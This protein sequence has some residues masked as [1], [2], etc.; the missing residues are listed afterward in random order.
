[1]S[2]LRIS[3]ILSFFLVLGSFA[4]PLSCSQQ[5]SDV[6]RLLQQLESDETTD[7]AAEQLLKLGRSDPKARQDLVRHLP[8]MIQKGP[9]ESRP[10]SNAVQ[11]AG[12]LK[13]A[14]AAP[15]LAKW[16]YE[17]A[18]GTL[19]LATTT[20]LEDDPAAKALAQIGDPSLPAVSPLLKSSNLNKR[21]SAALVLYNIGTPAAKNTLREHLKHETDASLRDFIR[22]SLQ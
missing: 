14:E 1:M 10:W 11:L 20:R 21:W 6:P 19:T 13:I 15:G 9:V 18:G 22:K 16:I 3:T 8:L 5:S 12:T 7:S 4:S 17:D 2:F